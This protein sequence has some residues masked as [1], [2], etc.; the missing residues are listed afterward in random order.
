MQFIYFYIISY[1]IIGYGILLSKYLNIKKYNFGYLGFLGL[2]LFLII[3]F[4]S[5][6]ILKHDYYLNS[7]FILTGLFLFFVNIFQIKYLKKNILN[8]FIIFSL[9][10]IFIMVAKNHDDFHY[11]HFPY[12]SLLTEFNHPI[13]LGLLN[14]GFRSP[15]SI[16]FIGSMFYLPGV[17]IYIFHITSALILGFS[18]LILIEKIFDKE[19]FNSSKFINFLSL[20]SLIFINIFFYRLAEYGTDRSGMLIVI[21]AIISFLTVINLKNKNQE[22]EIKFLILILCFAIT[23][24]PF[25][26]I[27]IPLIMLLFFYEKTRNIFLNLFFKRIFWYCFLLIFFIIFYTFINTGCLFFPLSL[28][29]FQNLPWSIDLKI[30][31]DVKIWFELW[32]KAGASP[33]YIVEDRNLYI[34]NF[35]WID[36]WIDQYFFNKFSDFLLG[37]F[38]LLF[39]ILGVFKNDLNNISKKNI[40]FFYLYF[41]IVCFLIEWFYFHPALRYGGYHL[42]FLSIFIPFSIFLDKFNI[43]YKV[44]QKKAFILIIVTIIIFSFRN[45]HRLSKEY[46]KYEYNPLINLNYKF[47]GA[48]E[49][50]HYRYNQ[51]IKEKFSNYNSFKILGKKFIYLSR[52]NY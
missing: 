35:N 8:H 26:L 22:Y 6:L 13:G 48:N 4:F 37:L 43:N 17:S 12:M 25:Y 36:N 40:R 44:F 34:S 3:S 52:D 21:I 38:I 29:C 39:I 20:V 11:Y 45:I 24:K 30:V 10:L 31:E 5:S 47:I 23:L 15:S 51:H 33:N 41:L 14:N 1:S 42:V 32:S 18:N 19:T 16:F 9:L 49:D 28:T 27:N 2:T 50:Y 46:S 7:F